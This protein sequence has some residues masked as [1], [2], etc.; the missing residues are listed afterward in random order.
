[1]TLLLVL[2]YTILA[3]WVAAKYGVWVAALNL[4]AFAWGLFVWHAKTYQQAEEQ[5]AWTKEFTE[6]LTKRFTEELEAKRESKITGQK[7]EM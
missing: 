4:A 2:M 7:Y 5:K 3:I 6:A 1:M